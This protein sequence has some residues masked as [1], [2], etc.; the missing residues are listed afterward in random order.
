MSNSLID[1]QGDAEC[2]ECGRELQR[3]EDPYGVTYQCAGHDC[4]SLFTAAEIEQP[5][6]AALKASSHQE[7]K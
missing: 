6:S 4:Y 2:P 5:T 7:E 3:N 1:R